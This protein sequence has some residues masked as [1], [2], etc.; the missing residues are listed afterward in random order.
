VKRKWLK[1]ALLYSLGLSVLG[2][3]VWRNWDGLSEALS[4]PIRGAP[5]ALAALLC[6]FNVLQT[7]VRWYLLVRAQGL[8]FTLR[9]ALRLGLIGYYFNT[10]APG[11]VGGDLIKAVGIAREQERR[12]VAVATI[13]VDRAIGLWALVTLVA[14]SG[15]LF[16]LTEPDVLQ[17]A[18][19]R[20]IVL[21]AAGLI[22][23]SILCWLLLG[24]LPDRRAQRFALRLESVP[25]LGGTLAELWRAGWMYRSKSKVMLIAIGMSL[26]G[27]C[28]S[29]LMFFFVVSA[30]QSDGEPRMPSLRQHFL[31]IPVGMI[32]Q[33]F[34]PAPG[35]VG[36][37]EAIFGWLYSL[38]GFPTEIGVLGSLGQRVLTW[39]LGAVGFVVYTF[40]KRQL[41]EKVKEP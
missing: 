38:L 33:A 15:A 26:V 40:M 22:G 12:S 41:P 23:G 2:Y 35:G 17:Q 7:F 30:F 19:L 16:W 37:G 4:Q 36:G 6:V 13:I 21:V 3:V 9:N 27:H 20:R 18:Y 10:V 8:P 39:V 34:F 24:L 31:I 5:Y 25:K 14:A 11:S 29:V 1:T 28:C 32:V